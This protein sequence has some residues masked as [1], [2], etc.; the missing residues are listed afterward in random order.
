MKALFLLVTLSIISGCSTHRQLPKDFSFRVEDSYEL[1]FDRYDSEKNEYQ[2]NYTN[3]VSKIKVKLTNEEKVLI[4][5]YF[6]ETNF[7]N[8]PEEFKSIPNKDGE[9][10]LSDFPETTIKISL[11][12]NG[13]SKIVLYNPDGSDMFRFVIRFESAFYDKKQIKNKKN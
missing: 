9:I 11:K 2:R 3:R 13:S 5:S 8:F 1:A 6:E 10:D 7:S 12:S 4:N